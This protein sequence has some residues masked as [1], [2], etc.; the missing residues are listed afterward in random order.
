MLQNTMDLQRPV[1]GS[2][3]IL[4]ADALLHHPQSY[5][6]LIICL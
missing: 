2:L 4:N 3:K 1:F 5:A 6:L